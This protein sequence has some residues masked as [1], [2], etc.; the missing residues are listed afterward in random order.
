DEPPFFVAQPLE[1]AARG[2]D[3]RLELGE[4]GLPLGARA[5]ERG[6]LG[7]APGRKRIELGGDGFRFDRDAAG[8]FEVL[9]HGAKMRTA[10]P[11]EISR[12]LLTQQE[13]QELGAA[14][15]VRDAKLLGEQRL[16]A[17]KT[18]VDRGAL[19]LEL[20]GTA[21]R[22]VG[23]RLD[24]LERLPSCGDLELDPAQRGRRLAALRVLSLEAPL[25][26]ADAAA[27]VV[28]L[29]LLVSLGLGGSANEQESRERRVEQRG[30]AF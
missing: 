19:G 27:H 16:L 13:L 7:G 9:G 30:R 24:L 8:I 15:H 17:G 5:L 4:K 28:E 6:E 10:G 21:P 3:R 14:V 26:L 18:T 12:A 1:L 22:V 2:R 20:R 11:A 23:S 25:E 29:G